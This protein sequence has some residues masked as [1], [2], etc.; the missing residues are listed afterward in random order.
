LRWFR[1]VWDMRTYYIV[2]SLMW[3]MK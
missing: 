2:R 3:N 1:W